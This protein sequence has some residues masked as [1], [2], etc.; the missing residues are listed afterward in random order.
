MKCTSGA[1]GFF[2]LGRKIMRAR[3]FFAAF[4]SACAA[5]FLFVA[6]ANAFV[7]LSARPFVFRSVA[8]VPPKYTAVVPGAGARNGR[9]SFVFRD[10]IEG[11]VSLMEAG[12]AEKIIVSGDHGRKDYDEVNSA[13]SYM[14]KVHGISDGDVFLDH[15][16]FS[17]YDTMYRARDVFCVRDAVIVTQPFH[18]ARCVFIA[19]ALGL[20]AVAYVAP[21]LNRLPRRAKI[22][23]E[24]RESLA[25]VKAVIDVVSRAKPVY[26]GEQ[27]PVTG[28]SAAT[29]D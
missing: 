7:V 26:L 6:V 20:D 5:A 8:D 12:R 19:R 14:K 21:E 16:G 1:A 9:V 17:T 28:S 24:I 23:W 10:R 4:F 3:T 29:R 13:L 22:V 27:I 25:R 2:L 15:A 11:A 18:A